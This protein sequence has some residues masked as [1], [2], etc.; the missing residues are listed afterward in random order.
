MFLS[1][2]MFT[3]G[4]ILWQKLSGSQKVELYSIYKSPVTLTVL[5]YLLQD[6][7]WL[8]S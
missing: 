4:Y 8:S 6:G 7:F 3:Q 2:V 5:L 1:W